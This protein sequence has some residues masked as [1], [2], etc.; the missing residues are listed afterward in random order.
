[1]I[2]EL[3]NKTVLI[4]GSSG[5]LGKALIKRL[6]QEECS[7]IQIDLPEYDLRNEIL[8]LRGIDFVFHLASHISK[9][10][11]LTIQECEENILMTKNIV[12]KN[13]KNTKIIYVSGGNVYGIS[14]KIPI[15]ENFKTKPIDN[16]GKSKLLCE[17][18]VKHYAKLRK[19]PFVILRISNIWGLQ[20]RRKGELLDKLFSNLLKNKNIEL[21][22]K[23]V[24]R[25]RVWVDD[26]VKAL[27][28]STKESVQGIFNIGSGQSFSTKFIVSRVKTKLKSRS[29]IKFMDGNDIIIDNRLNIAK[30]KKVLKWTPKIKIDKGLNILK[31]KWL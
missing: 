6:E 23:N 14:K 18:E 22:G 11:D 27:I 25:D 2:K 12:I 29:K 5:R 17:K 28:L 16:Y 19:F 31:E 1:M 26:V 7:I 15:K 24:K 10:K 13:S 20:F 9:G 3:K 30:A 4:T 8:N 21:Y